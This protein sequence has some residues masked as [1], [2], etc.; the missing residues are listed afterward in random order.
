VLEVRGVEQQ[1]VPLR[2]GVHPGHADH[3]GGDVV[4]VDAALVE[5]A[6]HRLADRRARPPP[7]PTASGLLGPALAA[8]ARWALRS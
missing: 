4:R 5:R 1:L 2:L 3:A 6:L 7:G 8:Y